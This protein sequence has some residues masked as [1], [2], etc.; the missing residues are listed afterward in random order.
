MRYL[1]FSR[2][3]IA[4]FFCIV[5]LSHKKRGV[6][7]MDTLNVKSFGFMFINISYFFKKRQ[8]RGL[9]STKYI[10]KNEAK[11]PIFCGKISHNNNLTFISTKWNLNTIFHTK[12]EVVTRTTL[13]G[14]RKVRFLRKIILI[15][16]Q[17]GFSSMSNITYYF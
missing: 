1:V 6:H 11:L 5:K 8:S 3:K 10:T 9:P 4:L 2:Y 12:K 17:V 14:K 13:K 16:K 15:T 7:K